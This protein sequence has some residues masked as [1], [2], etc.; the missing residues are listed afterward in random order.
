MVPSRQHSLVMVD[1]RLVKSEA[2]IMDD[3]Q[4]HCIVFGYRNR[5]LSKETEVVDVATYDQDGSPKDRQI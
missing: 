1:A 5:M 4:V 2:S 3:Y